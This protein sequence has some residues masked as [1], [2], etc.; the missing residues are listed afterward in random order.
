ML[1]G[2][3]RGSPSTRDLNMGLRAGCSGMSDSHELDT[4][5]L[6]DD[7]DA[8]DAVK[9]PFSLLAP[10][11]PYL[12]EFGTKA[13]I[14]RTLKFLSQRRREM[15]KSSSDGTAK[16]RF[17]QS[18]SHEIPWHNRNGARNRKQDVDSRAGASADR[19]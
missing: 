5:T 2:A 1:A 6:N 12:N 7:E 3:P 19:A 15:A 10:Q 8:P 18:P 11:R 13:R 17:L 9:V 16:D 4:D 14:H